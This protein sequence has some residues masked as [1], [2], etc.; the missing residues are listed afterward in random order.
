MLPN[1]DI[2]FRYGSF[3]KDQN[4]SLYTETTLQNGYTLLVDGYVR[5]TDGTQVY[6]TVTVQAGKQP[7]KTYPHGTLKTVNGYLVEPDG[8]VNRANGDRV[9]PGGEVSVSVDNLA[10]NCG[11]TIPRGRKGYGG[12]V[13]QV[14]SCKSSGAVYDLKAVPE[15]GFSFIKWLGACKPQGSNPICTVPLNK[16]QRKVKAIFKPL[17]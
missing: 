7:P 12:R 10:I 15:T 8:T 14:T 11:K 9:H 5:L 16:A 13:C 2:Y 4:G 1:G 6:P 17:K 3:W